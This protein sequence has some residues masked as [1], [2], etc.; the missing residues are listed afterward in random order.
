M[1]PTLAQPGIATQKLDTG[2]LLSMLGVDRPRT[3]RSCTPELIGPSGLPCW[4]SCPD[5][6]D[7]EP[8]GDR[9]NASRGAERVLIAGHIA[10]PDLLQ[11][12][13]DRLM[14]FLIITPHQS[15]RNDLYSGWTP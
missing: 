1:K 5:D 14:R 4:E 10:E 7:R 6:E 2:A 9:R 15:T 11:I 3:C 13:A 8:N 12:G